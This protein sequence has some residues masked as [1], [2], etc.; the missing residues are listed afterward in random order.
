MLIFFFSHWISLFFLILLIPLIFF[1]HQIP[2]KL[3]QI[4][5]EQYKQVNEML[6][7]Q[8]MYFSVKI[9]D[10][11]KT[12]REEDVMPLQNAI[13]AFLDG[14]SEKAIVE[15]GQK[16][17]ELVKDLKVNPELKLD[18]V[19]F[20]DYTIIESKSKQAIDGLKNLDPEGTFP[21]AMQA[22]RAMEIRLAEEEWESLN[23]F[24]PKVR[25]RQSP[26]KSN[27]YHIGKREIFDSYTMVCEIQNIVSLGEFYIRNLDLKSE[28]DQFLE[29]FQR[30]YENR[31][32]LR[33]LSKSYVGYFAAC[34]IKGKWHR[35]KVHSVVK[36]DRNVFLL[37]AGLYAT[38]KASELIRLH[39]QF[40]S[41]SQISIKCC[42]GEI[43]PTDA[44][45]NF[46]PKA[47]NEFKSIVQD[48]RAAQNYFRVEFTKDMEQDSDKAAPCIVKICGIEKETK[49]INF[50]SVLVTKGYA[51]STGPASMGPMAYTDPSFEQKTAEERRQ[52]VEQESKDIELKIRKKKMRTPTKHVHVDILNRKMCTPDNVLVT[53]KCR[54]EEFLELDNELQEGKEN[55]SSSSDWKAGDLCL[56]FRVRRGQPNGHWC[57]GKIVD[58]VESE[59]FHVALFDYGI[60]EIYPRIVLQD[61]PEKYKNIPQ[62]SF[63][64]RLAHA[65]PGGFASFWSDEAIKTFREILSHYISFAISVVTEADENG[66]T[67]VV[68]YGVVEKIPEQ[69]H[70]ILNYMCHKGLACKNQTDCE[71]QL[72]KPWNLKYYNEADVDATGSE[73]LQEI[74]EEE[75][76][77]AEIKKEEP[78]VPYAE[79]KDG[80]SLFPLKPTIIKA[81]PPAN[82][83]QLEQYLI[84]RVYHVDRDGIFYFQAADEMEQIKEM[85]RALT[86]HYRNPSA[87]SNLDI[88]H[89]TL[90][91][92]DCVIARYFED[93]SKFKK[94]AHE[95]L[96]NN[97]FFSEVYYRAMIIRQSMLNKRAYRT[98]FVDFGNYVNVS[99]NDIFAKVISRIFYYI[100]IHI[101]F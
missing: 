87:I 61:M 27:N 74:I 73:L 38:V 29:N 12:V 60:E 2:N 15:N 71:E 21:V 98:Q 64:L 70:D 35:V 77:L 90:S 68:L 34:K 54:D 63:K 6:N 11:A 91:P 22:L 62:F 51:K 66:I 48:Q 84:G 13:Q 92:G 76:K 44:K 89:K 9:N 79:A 86:Q 39:D 88:Q 4:L 37:D 80:S 1:F 17:F 28:Q 101:V 56:V 46:P 53:V 65:V 57:R 45:E 3:K 47:L 81:W 83:F 96:N 25:L 99:I 32:N 97:L 93:G 49:I 41:Q 24:A 67:S 59:R 36:F 40:Y 52:K 69:H 14:S 19:K 50:N 82:P 95:N 100:E 42:F 75:K 78:P 30:F 10:L 7:K 85:T 94:I 26:K 23:K 5:N 31:T 43:E 8:F 33:N 72:V 18:K 55:K 20:F 58:K 16:V